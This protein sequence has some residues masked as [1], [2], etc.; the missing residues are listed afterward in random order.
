M[1][2]GLGAPPPVRERNG[3]AI[4]E[5][6]CFH[7]FRWASDTRRQLQNRRRNAARGGQFFACPKC[8][9]TDYMLS[10]IK[11]H[12]ATWWDRVLAWLRGE[13]P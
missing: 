7:C 4:A 10:D 5:G 11:L 2:A 9:G 13:A 3:L 6:C 12:Q 1:N 8:G